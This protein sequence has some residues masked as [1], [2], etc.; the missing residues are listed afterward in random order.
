MRLVPVHQ[1]TFDVGVHILQRFDVPSGSLKIMWNKM[2]KRDCQ[3]EHGKEVRKI[4]F[5]MKIRRKNKKFAIINFSFTNF[6][7]S[8]LFL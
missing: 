7:V 8:I 1:L 4:I 3:R 5:S 2:G 6:L